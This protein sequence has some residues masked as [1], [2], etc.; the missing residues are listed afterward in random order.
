MIVFISAV[1]TDLASARVGAKLL[2]P[3][4]PAVTV[5]A[6]RDL[7]D[8]AA[9]ARALANAR[10]VILRILGG[11]S[12]FEHGFSA[13]QA[14]ARE[15]PLA[16]LAI[17]GDA[18]ADPTL[19]A[20]SSASLETLRRTF[21]YT[22][23]GGAHNLAH[24]FRYVADAQLGTAFGFA[25]PQ[26][27]PEWGL[28]HP[29]APDRAACARLRRDAFA[30]LYHR[31]RRATIGIVFY[32]ADWAS[33]NL[34]H[35]DALV[36]ACEALDLNVLPVFVYSLRDCDR[37]G[38]MPRVYA[39]EFMREGKACVDVVISFLSYAVSDLSRDERMTR[40]TGPALRA[41]IA[42]DVPLIQAATS[43]QTL[44]EWRN[45]PAGLGPLDA[46][47]KIVM[48]EF[49]GKIIGPVFSFR[50]ATTALAAPD[51]VQTQAL[52]RLAARYARLRRTPNRQKR[53][54]IVLTN[55]ANRQ[56]RVGGAVGLDTPASVIALLRALEAE[57]YDAGTIPADGNALMSALLARGG[58]DADALT[59][60]QLLYADARY[61]VDAYARE[62]GRVSARV[63]ADMQAQ[64][65][66]APGDAFRVNDDLY[67]AGLR[68]GN[69]FVMIQPPR[70]FGENP[71]AVYHSNDLVPTHHYLAAYL[72]LRDVFR[73]DAIVQCGKHGTL[74]W[75]PGKSVG[76]SPEC[77]P[78]LAIGDLPFFY[79]FIVN[80]PG[81]GM[82]AK[83][84]AHACIVDHLVPPMTRAET[85]D[86]LAKLQRLLG[87]YA[88]AERTD[89]EKLPLISSAVWQ[90]VI[91]ADL[92]RDL[93]VET[94]PEQEH[95]GEFLQHIDGY[96]C[97]LGDLQIRDG[98]HVL[99]SPPQGGRLIDLA[100]ALVRLDAPE[101]PGILHALADDFGIAYDAIADPARAGMR[102]DGALPPDF[103]AEPAPTVREL[104]EKLE[105]IARTIVAEL[106]VDPRER[107]S[108][109]QI[110][111]LLSD[112]RL[113]PDG[114]FA[115]TLRALT[116]SIVPNVL[117][118]TDEITN[119]L[120]GL[121]G[122]HVPP[123][124]S[125]A[126]T[127]GMVNVLP[128]GKNFY[129]VD[130]RAIPSRFAWT[131][132]TALG[133]A[134][135]KTA[136]ERGG[137][138]PRS[139]AMTVWGTANM[140]TQGDDV[141][142]IFWLLGVRPVW[143]EENG[144]V[145]DLEIIP[146]Q[147]LGRPRVDVV[148]RIS[149]FFR[150]TFPGVVALLDR[151]VALI[152]DLDESAADNPLRAAA[153]SDER[154]RIA[155]GASA[156]EARRRS[157]FRVFGN[158]PGAYGAGVL[159]HIA[160][161]SWRD[162]RDL[163]ETYLAAGSFAYGEH[164]YGEPAP[165]EFR[166]R[167]STAAI[168][169]Q[170]QDN[171]EHDIFDND[172]YLQHHGGMIAAMRALG[173]DAASALFGDSSDPATPKART[174]AQEAHRVFRSRAANP[175]WIAGMR[176]HGYKGALEMAATVD[177]LFGYDATA[178][179]MEDWMYERVAQAYLLDEE[180]RAFLQEANPWSAHE[181]TERLLEAVERGLWAQPDA[182]TLEKL[183]EEF[184]SIEGALEDR[185]GVP[186]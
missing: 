149:G 148:V 185:S 60:E 80:D 31:D 130:V 167:L 1:E 22:F 104:R 58:Y 126:P 54:A 38:D 112:H 136:H 23:A 152:A 73:A 79:P 41:D 52:A 133:D 63:R 156:S 18:H 27:T 51:P 109:S 141:A 105:T 65:G 81:E 87:E 62:H 116:Q 66:P 171:R 21:A 151:A 24:L 13:I 36:H 159:A 131:V 8:A 170:N 70:G 84:R 122:G 59:E 19:D 145:V 103:I 83:R 174:L 184:L 155:A 20:C 100:L 125:G 111:A 14:L 90:S 43:G 91:A 160:E 127:R 67:V 139:V 28:Y 177:Y 71:L 183:R 6:A 26:E 94:L 143:H 44:D 168:A 169:V 154:A 89:P 29:N 99:G 25:P 4:F 110:H 172:A 35:V 107:A 161:G 146:L 121:R 39:D 118:A 30:A 3:N 78:A 5:L 40:S 9:V 113:P 150:D 7:P 114:A 50:D 180:N 95:F 64:W 74:E 186:A 92:Q 48:P 98:L 163:G 158:K 49:D 10:V 157:R 137:A 117:R 33:A 45:N 142:E 11:R 17:P 72:W 86:E 56:G 134:L 166:A 120:A 12:Y 129:S 2:P 82:Q 165:A 68:L 179:V 106:L 140:R 102:Y 132:G 147:E 123:G 88:A 119:L 162:A 135:L 144:R 53:I 108:A 182:R 34:A 96:L 85:Y 173:N 61:P 175:K 115:R 46:A 76:L 37:A 178:G 138:Y 93:G 75:L 101:A 164:V 181:M 32:R 57:G 55:F 42:L 16:L 176:R 77:Y 69:I 47:T 15:R 153:R 124:P 128:T 97:E